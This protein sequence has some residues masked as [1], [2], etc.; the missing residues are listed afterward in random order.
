MLSKSLC[1]LEMCV[2]KV[3]ADRVY[4]APIALT[5]GKGI[6][7]AVVERRGGQDLVITESRTSDLRTTALA[8]FLMPGVD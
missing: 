5:V 6:T 8:G 4:S 7:G 3:G 1:L 2:S